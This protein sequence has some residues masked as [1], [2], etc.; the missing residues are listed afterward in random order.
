MTSRSPRLARA[1]LGAAIL[2]HPALA[3]SARAAEPARPLREAITVDPGASCLDAASLMDQVQSWV[4]TDAVDAGVG[5]E[6]R[7]SPD[8]PR[9][10]GFRILRGGGV[11]AVR[12]FDPGPARC[13]QLHAVL[14]LA[15]AMALK[16]SLI[17]EIAQTAAPTAAAVVAPEGPAAAIEAPLPWS[18]AVQ[19]VVALAVLPD[20]AFGVDVRAE[21]AIVHALRVRLG[22]FGVL[23]SGETFDSAPGHFTTWLFAPRL[24]L[25]ASLALVSHLQAH[26]CMGMSGGWL[27]AQGFS[28]PSSQSQFIRWLAVANELGLR[29]ELSRHW[30][31][32]LD[33]TL[34]LPVAR[35]SIVV[36]DYSGNVI[37]QRDLAP[38]GWIFG[39]GP[40]FRF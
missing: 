33:A 27:H 12:T 29:A 28:Y 15:I 17:E 3:P 20:A 25:C 14:G 9:V 26:G 34:V 35:N 22:V 30:A 13:E 23:A 5:V 40:L 16:A 39:A 2:L 32:D 10:V 19:P 7:G 36:R 21:R 11:A 6:V 31:I 4:G 37:L 38:A 8:Q 18:A 1:V 24:D